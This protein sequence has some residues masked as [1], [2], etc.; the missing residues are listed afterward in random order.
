MK[1]KL[2]GFIDMKKRKGKVLFCILPEQSGVVGLPVEKYFIYNDLSDKIS[3]SS[4]G[5]E[6]TIVWGNYNGNAIVQDLIFE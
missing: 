5:K 3:S 2:T 6:F 4:I 1:V